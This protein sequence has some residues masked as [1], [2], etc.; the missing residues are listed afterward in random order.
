MA[1]KKSRSRNRRPA[2]AVPSAKPSAAQAPPKPHRAAPA[3]PAA[4]PP[5]GG[6]RD[7]LPLGGAAAVAVISFVVYCLTVQ[8]SVPTGDSGE[9]IAAAYTAGIAHPPGYPLYMMLGYVVSHLPGLSPA[10]WMNVFSGVLDA[11]AVGIV[12]LIIHRLVSPAGR[13]WLPLA[14]AACGSLLLAF[15]TG[16]WAYSVV[17]EV[18]A[19]NNL[20][21]ALL[22]YLAIEWARRPQRAILLWAFMFVLGLALCNQQTIVLFVPAFV[23]LAV[24]GWKLLPTTGSALKLPG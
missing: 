14:A 21:A 24:R 3:R 2:M 20:L 13:R 9:L 1:S 5:E 12:F 15:S 19:L 16:F 6:P 7:W 10:T 4:P 22:L 17:A 18:F 11:L 8:H 23:I